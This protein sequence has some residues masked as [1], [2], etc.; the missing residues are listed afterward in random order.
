MRERSLLVLDEFGK[1]TAPQD[2]IALFL[3]MVKHLHDHNPPH[4]FSLLSTHFSDYLRS[5][6]NANHLTTRSPSSRWNRYKTDESVL[7]RFQRRHH[8]SLPGRRWHLSGLPRNSMCRRD[9]ASRGI[10]ESSGG[11]RKRERMGTRSSRQFTQINQSHCLQIL[12]QQR[13]QRH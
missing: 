3:A 13:T 7:R 9:G 5:G 6:R 11:G 12:Q 4:C 2:G 1:G 8:A 10:H